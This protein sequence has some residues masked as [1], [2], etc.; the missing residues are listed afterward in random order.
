V[1]VYPSQYQL[2]ELTAHVVALLERRRAAFETWDEKTEAALLEEAKRALD[3]A[4]R[5]FRELADDP[6]YWQRTVELLMTVALPRYFRVAK[7]QHGLE[8]RKYDL[9]RGGDFF[10]RAAFALGGLVVGFVVLR[11]ALPDWLEP[12]PL[13][14]FI[15]GPLIPDVQVWLAKRRYAKQLAGLVDEMKA[16]AADRRT[17]QPLGIDEHVAGGDAAA[18]ERTKE[19]L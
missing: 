17:Y 7:T 9:W 10:A 18:P 14:F 11:T 4:G 13:A 3:E 6:A 12:I 2:P 1:N 8:Q 5:Q 16:E 19:K 15:G